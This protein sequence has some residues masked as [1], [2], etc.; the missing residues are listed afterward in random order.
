[1]ANLKYTKYQLPYSY[2]ECRLKYNNISNAN[3]WNLALGNLYSNYEYLLGV[4]E[5]YVEKPEYKFITT[6]PDINS[7]FNTTYSPS[8]NSV[9]GLLNDVVSIDS[10]V[11]PFNKLLIVLAY[12]NRLVFVLSDFNYLISD[13]PT[14][15]NWNYA[16]FTTIN[17]SGSFLYSNIRNIKINSRNEL[18]V[19]DGTNTIYKY[20]INDSV[21]SISPITKRTYIKTLTGSSS[22]SFKQVFKNIQDICIDH[23]D[24]LVV[25]DEGNVVKFFDSSL[26][27]IYEFTATNGFNIAKFIA[28]NSKNIFIYFDKPDVTSTDVI[29]SYDYLGNLTWS[30]EI[31]TGKTLKQ[32][33]SSKID[34]D[35]CVLVYEDLI[36]KVSRK[37]VNYFSSLKTSIITENP[38]K[39]ASL[40]LYNGSEYL[41]CIDTD[42]MSLSVSDYSRL[43]VVDELFYK[44][45]Q[46]SKSEIILS[47]NSLTTDVQYNIILSKLYRNIYNMNSFINYK[48][49]RRTDPVLKTE[50]VEKYMIDSNMKFWNND[51][52]IYSALMSQ[53]E[54]YVMESF[55]KC[56]YIIW[57]IQNHVLGLMQYEYNQLQNDYVY[58]Q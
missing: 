29:A 30:N 35:V 44:V 36:H 23:L 32:I 5:S 25:L 51:H 28:A 37:Y 4:S 53:N 19:L 52:T 15:I 27:F 18:F 17:D 13:Y 22:V 57:N 16:T 56:V 55:N 45:P 26:N 49:N 47:S 2:S 3:N 38:H 33:S 40:N 41:L 50:I 8:S 43:S 20:N 46:Y 42:Y 14:I 58:F 6:Y 34:N 21:S 39:C 31:T 9:G 1:M 54:Y 7:W 10:V 48:L 12:T 24:R 11:T